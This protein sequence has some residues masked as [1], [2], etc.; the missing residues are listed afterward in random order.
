[1]S[2]LNYSQTIYLFQ[3]SDPFLMQCGHLWHFI[4]NSASPPF[5]TYKWRSTRG[6]KYDSRA[7]W[8]LSFFFFLSLSLNRES[9]CHLE[10]SGCWNNT[11]WARTRKEIFAGCWEGL[12]AGWKGTEKQRRGGSKSSYFTD[13]GPFFF[14]TMWRCVRVCSLVCAART[15]CTVKWWWWGWGANLS[16]ARHIH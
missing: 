3:E 5:L 8:R 14:C 1:M 12:S 2:H 10:L 4:N 11:R 13:S 15:R 7:P 6:G 9:E 16:S